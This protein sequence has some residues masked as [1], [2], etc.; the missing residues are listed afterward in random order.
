MLTVADECGM[1][2]PF[3]HFNTSAEKA[4]LQFINSFKYKKSMKRFWKEIFF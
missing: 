1:K 3:F 4:L 2:S